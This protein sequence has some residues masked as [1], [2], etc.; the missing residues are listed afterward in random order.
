MRSLHLSRQF[1]GVH[2]W[3]SFFHVTP[4]DQRR[5]LHFCPARRAK[6][7]A[8]AGV[9]IKQ[10]LWLQGEYDFMAITELND[11]AAA[12]TFGLNIARQGNVRSQTMRAFRSRKWRR[13]CRTS[14]MFI[15]GPATRYPAAGF[16]CR[17]SAITLIQDRQRAAAGA[18]VEADEIAKRSPSTHNPRRRSLTAPSPRRRPRTRPVA[19]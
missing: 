5:M 17:A 14:F 7:A 8:Q 3:D 4:D 15:Q 11:E 18:R 13:Y 10:V 6:A 9:T 1:D 16:A 12:T 19:G 2:A